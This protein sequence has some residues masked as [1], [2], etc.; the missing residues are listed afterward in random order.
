MAARFSVRI[1]AGAKRDIARIK[2]D[3]ERR[4][5]ADVARSV[6]AN[7]KAKAKSLETF[8]NRGPVVPELLDLGIQRYREVLIYPYRMIY[9]VVGTEAR[10]VLVADGRRDFVTLLEQHLLRAL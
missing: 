4:A 1:S 7:I 8:A 6:Q 9:E 3:L 10:I 2:R 5:D